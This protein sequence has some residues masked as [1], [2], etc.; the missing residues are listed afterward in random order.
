MAMRYL[1]Q[2]FWLAIRAP[3]TSDLNF[4]QTIDGCTSF[5]PANEAKPQSALAI[6]RSRPTMSANRAMRCATSSGCSTSTVDCVITPGM[7]TLSSGSFTRFHSCHSCSCP[8]FAAF[9]H[10]LRVGILVDSFPIHLGQHHLE[11]A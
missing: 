4:A 3:S 7:S 9:A 2:S 5:D 11:D 8:W 1:L 6:T 10:T